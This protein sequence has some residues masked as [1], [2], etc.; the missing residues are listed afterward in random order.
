MIV[1]FFLVFF[2]LSYFSVGGTSF[3]LAKEYD[4]VIGIDY[5]QA[6]IDAA[7]DMKHNDLHPVHFDVPM[8]GDF[9]STVLCRHE[10]EFDK[11]QIT[12][13]QGDACSLNEE[14]LGQFDV[15]ALAN[16]I[17]RLPEPLKC[18][19]S[20]ERM[21]KPNGV[22]VMTTPFSWLETYTDKEN[23]LGGYEKDGAAVHSEDTLKMEMEARGFQRIYNEPF[24]L[25]IREHQRKYQYIV[26]N[27]SAWKKI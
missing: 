12:F 18:L 4:E 10:S 14:E 6:F 26:A 16:L 19:D 15:V 11:N 21:V 5:S 1:L 23:W 8:E 17:C 3:A 9:A 13:L 2:F 22:V 25:T 27:G 7:N 20:L 24:P